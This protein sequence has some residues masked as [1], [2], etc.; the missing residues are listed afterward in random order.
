MSDSPAMPQTV[1]RRRLWLT[2]AVVTTVALTLL[3]IFSAVDVLFLLFLGIL[4]A[5]L[6][7]GLSNLLRSRTGLSYGLAL[8]VVGVS[9]V[10]LLTLLVVLLGPPLAQQFNQ[11][12]EKIP[13][14]VEQIRASLRDTAWGQQILNQLPD[15]DQLTRFLTTGSTNV[16]TRATGIVSSTLGTLANAFIVLFV[17]IYLAIEPG[18]YVENG[19][20]LL[21]EHRRPRAR[22]VL[23]ALRDILQR[24]LFARFTSMVVVGA[25]TTLGLAAIGMPLA[26]TLGIIAGILSFIPNLGPILAIVPAA[27]VAIS[28]GAEQVLIVILLYMGVQAIESYLIT[29]LVE[30]RTVS[31]PPAVTLIAQLLLSVIVGFLGLLLAAPLVA[32][33]IVLVRMLYIEDVLGDKKD[34]DISEQGRLE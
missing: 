19:L 31:L 16:L 14:S 1:F 32:V 13:Q 5:V 10:L 22:E 28:N 4:L 33:L 29:P 12:I 23:A 6:L 21:P 11:L 3:I 30:R 24:W 20:R 9:L 17:G 27:L 15:A 34:P 26:L 25:L 18:L 2:I 7:N 8:G